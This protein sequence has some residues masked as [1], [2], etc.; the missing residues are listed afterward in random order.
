[1]YVHQTN[2]KMFKVVKI[3]MCV[4]C[5][6]SVYIQNTICDEIAIGNVAKD[7]DIFFRRSCYFAS[8]RGGKDILCINFY[9]FW[10]NE[11]M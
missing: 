2:R 6:V 3:D 4:L 10:E 1:M 8:M 7:F 9:S 5:C 11:L